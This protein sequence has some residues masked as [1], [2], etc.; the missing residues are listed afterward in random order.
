MVSESV[1]C[2][3]QVDPVYFPHLE[4]VGDIGN[5]IWQIKESLADWTP[6]W[7][8]RHSSH[9]PHPLI[10][11]RSLLFS[12]SSDQLQMPLSSR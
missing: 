8:L 10:I 2:G 12:A 1:A 6:T 3:R 7:D 11:T 9:H 5:A 4:V